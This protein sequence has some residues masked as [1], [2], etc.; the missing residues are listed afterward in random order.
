MRSVFVVIV[1]ILVDKTF[2]VRF[3]HRNHAVAEIPSAA[4]FQPDQNLRAKTQEILS[5]ARSLSH[6]CSRF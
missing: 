3:S 6:G 2:Q 5:N 1:D 4:C